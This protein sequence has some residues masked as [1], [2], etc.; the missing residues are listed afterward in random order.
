MV[1]TGD[2]APMNGIVL[3]SVWFVPGAIKLRVVC[4]AA[5]PLVLPD[6]RKLAIPLLLVAKSVPLSMAPCLK[7][8]ARFSLPLRPE[9]IYLCYLR[10]VT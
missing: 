8:P 4:T 3:I 1:A 6:L 9:Y 2:G 10:R 5:D 7:Y